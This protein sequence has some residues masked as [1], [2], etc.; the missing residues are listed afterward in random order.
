M[1]HPPG[2]GK[3]KESPKIRNLRPYIIGRGW[4]PHPAAAD[5]KK[6]KEKG[7]PKNQK[8]EALYNREGLGPSTRAAADQTRRKEKG[9]PKNQKFE[10][11]YNREGLGPPP[12]SS[13]KPKREGKRKESPKIRNL[14]PYI[15]GRGWG[16]H[17]AAADQTR[18]KEKGKPKNHKFEAL[19]NREGLGPP[20]GSGKRK[21]SPKIRNL[22]PYIIGKGWGPPPSSEKERKKGK[23]KNQKFEALYNRE[24]L[25]PPPG[26]SGPKE[27]EREK[28]KPKNQKFE[29]L[30]RGWAA[31]DQKKRKEKGKPKNQK[32]EALYN[33]EGLGPP[34]GSSG[35][36]E[37]ERQKG[38]PKIRNLTK[39]KGKRK[40]SPKI[41]NLR[42]YIIGRGW[43]P[44]RQRKEKGK[45]KNQKFEALYSREGLGPPPGSGK[46]KESPKIRNWR[47]YIIGRGWGPHLAAAERRKEKEREKGKPKNQKFEALYNREGLGPPPGSSGK[48]KREGK[49]ERKAQKSE[50]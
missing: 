27:K 42:P 13:G 47:P 34:P 16:P 4:A 17:P 22:R 8:F 37:K 3:R 41:R 23:P 21:E 36:K 44:T 20:P 29:A 18:R 28:G 38:K 31:K 48:P 11:L 12:G 30:Y 1:G 49:R 50:I 6:R 9:K 26:S 46:R 7:K 15:I 32:F 19:Y 40:E 25:G 35:P 39:R 43:A 14:R 45:P 24:G 33:R 10:A 5:Q 2:S